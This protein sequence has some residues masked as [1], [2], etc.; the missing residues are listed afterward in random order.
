MTN[1]NDLWNEVPAYA[2]IAL[3]RRGQEKISLDQC[4]L[5][6]C[7]NQDKKLLEPLKVEEIVNN[8]QIEIKHVHIKC[9]K[10]GGIFQLKLETIKK[11][12]KTTRKNSKEE[13]DD[14]FLSMGRIFA[15]DGTGK[16]LGE[17]GYF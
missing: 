7:D 17:I 13:M 2:Y 12:A 16:N 9:K 4:F 5:I 11:M 1:N 6:G 15:L 10:C 3:G 14:S 8:D